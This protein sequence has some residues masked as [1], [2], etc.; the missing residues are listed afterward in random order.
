MVTHVELRI[1][2]LLLNFINMFDKISVVY[3]KLL[4]IVKL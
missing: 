3:N 1:N 4:E 2:H